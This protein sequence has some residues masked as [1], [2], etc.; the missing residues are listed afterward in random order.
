MN[1]YFF[2]PLPYDQPD[3]L[4]HVTQ[5]DPV[6]GWHMYRFPLPIYE[7]WKARSRAFQD[8]GAYTYTGVNV[9]GPE[10]PESVNAARLSETM[11]DILGADAL[12]GRT[13][14]MGEGG[15]AG[16]RVAVIGHRFWQRRYAGDPNVLDRQI[17]IDGVQHYVI[18]VMPPDFNF[19]FGGIKLWVPI[20]EDLATADRRSAPYLL[21]GRMNDGWTRDQVD[22]DLTSVQQALSAEYPDADGKWAGV[23]VLPMRQALNFVWDILKVSFT[24]LLGAVVFVIMIACV[25]V[26]SLTFARAGGRTRE[27]A[28]R[29]ALGAQRSRVIRQLLTESL[30]LDIMGGTLGVA[31]AYGIAGFIGPMIPE[32]LYRIGEISV[33]RTVLAFSL[34]LTLVTP[35]A[36]GLA[37]A[38]SAT[39]RDLTLGLKEGS[40]GSGGLSTSRARKA[41]VVVQ[42]ALAVVLTTGAG[43]MLRS[44]ASVQGLDVGFDSGQVLTVSVRPP[45]AD[46][47]GAELRQYVERAVDE[48]QA[49]PGVT[50]ASPAMFIP[51]N[52]ESSIWQFAPPEQSGIPGEEWPTAIANRPYPGYFETMGIPVLAGRDFDGSD[53]S[54]AAPI[55]IVN[56]AL[57]DRYWP[58]GSAVGRTVLV[59]DPA[60]P[61]TATIVGVGGGVMHEALDGDKDRAQMYRPALQE[62]FLRHFLL[63]RTDGDPATLVGP[64]REALMRLDPNLPLSPRPIAQVVDE[65]ELQW[66]IGSGFLIVFGA[67]ALLLAT[68][69]IYGIISYSVSQREKELGVRIALGAT[70]GEI[71]KIVVGDGLKLASAGLGVGLVA[72][73]LLGQL[74]TAVLFEVS[75]FDPI[76]LWSVL[77]L[78]ASVAALASFMPARRAGRTDPIRVL[79]ME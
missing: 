50:A 27:I 74:L 22:Q 65:N 11:F 38:L 54:D 62:T 6:T 66:S 21:V 75:P 47:V 79:R 43:L 25:N 78:F 34:V 8:L 5:V 24:V 53:N 63:A 59:G 51:L 35:L 76:T 18:G 15:P 58:D 71:R 44:F 57:A 1:P 10:G 30:L 3:E 67:G 52:H 61:T 60:N 26:A 19:P 45:E 40:K 77:V 20:A 33:D 14:T 32:D 73:L 70:V 2:R 64:A 36:F 39:R 16:E 56:R 42:V 49:I 55:A 48:L 37:P 4:V 68:L 17:T 12:L 29:T 46:Y 13:F 69:G 41:L 28:V 9:T 31:L 23:T 72:S 7:D